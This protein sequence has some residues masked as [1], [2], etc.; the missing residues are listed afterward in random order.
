MPKSGANNRS[1]VLR[2]INSS[3]TKQTQIRQIKGCRWSPLLW[4]SWKLLLMWARFI[5]PTVLSHETPWL[6]ILIC[7]EALP[8]SSWGTYANKNGWRKDEDDQCWESPRAALDWSLSPGPDWLITSILRR[9]EEE[10]VEKERPLAN[11][12]VWTLTNGPRC[13]ELVGL[14]EKTTRFVNKLN[15]L[16]LIHLILAML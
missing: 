8:G 16:G 4:S 14:F 3:G 15:V 10:N 1:A 5:F 12:N 2:W 6:F 9:I 13:H 7:T 11:G